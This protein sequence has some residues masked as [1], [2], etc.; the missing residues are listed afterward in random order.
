MTF[1]SAI[2]DYPSSIIGLTSAAVEILLIRS[3]TKALRVF[4]FQQSTFIVMKRNYLLAKVAACVI[5][6]YCFSSCQNPDEN[7]PV[8]AEQVT[9]KSDI[10]GEEAYPGETGERK[11]G[12]LFG[13]EIYYREINNQAVFQNDII[14]SPE[15]LNAGSGENARTHATGLS[16]T[17][18]RW[19]GGVVYYTISTG[20]S[21]K[22]AILDA[23][24]EVESKTSVKFVNRTLQKNY[25]TFYSGRG[26]ASSLGMI[27]GQQF[28]NL[29]IPATKG[30]VLH[31]IGHTLGLL[32][33]HTRLDRNNTIK[34]NYENVVTELIEDFTPYLTQGLKAVTFKTFDLGSIMMVGPYTSSKNGY[35]TIALVNNQIYS[36]QRTSL[37]TRDVECINAMYASLY[38]IQS[39]KLYGADKSLPRNV[40]LNEMGV[41]AE[42]VTSDEHYVYT[43]AAGKI[44]RYHKFSGQSF[45]FEG[46]YY[47][48]TAM[49]MYAG[50]L[51]V[52]SNGYLLR[53][54]PA[55][56]ATT[57]VGQRI[58]YQTTAMS[59]INGFLFIINGA[60]IFRVAPQTGTFVKISTLDFTNCDQ[61]TA[62]NGKIWTIWGTVLKSTD[63]MTGAHSELYT[64]R[65]WS[66]EAMITSVG[67]YLY[68][69]DLGALYRVSTT[70]GA[71]NVISSGW[72]YD[73]RLTSIDDKD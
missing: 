51:Y 58:W 72:S 28:I 20:V 13:Q 37:S 5:S 46:N 56:G 18:T 33:E 2:L 57:Q 41:T 25:V 40:V 60:N 15:Q 68:I 35:P 45:T 19:P 65:I 67:S 1:R 43:A 17:V 62:G 7:S 27:G 14:L 11:T 38:I 53:I 55:N 54:N 50:N 6:V 9:S 8:N 48:V 23:I 42:E 73:T 64:G 29:P 63:P 36:I 59:Y 3:L 26:A 24:A 10:K 4:G 44:I 31:E 34:I 71:L 22:S 39:G 49:T 21:N 12:K 32:H 70:T 30:I 52:V 61:M 47:Q 69:L 66:V 16:E